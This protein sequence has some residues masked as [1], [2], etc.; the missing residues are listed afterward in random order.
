MIRKFIILFP[1]LVTSVSALVI[2]HDTPTLDYENYGAQAQFNASLNI[3][4]DGDAEFGALAGSTAID[5][6]WGIHARHTLRSVS[7]WLDDGNVARIRG[8]R[9][10]GVSFQG[11][12]SVVVNQ[13]IHYDDDFSRF[14]N[15]IDI[16]LVQSKAPHSG[17]RIAPIYGGWDEVGRVGSAASA[18]NNRNNGNGVSA[19]QEAQD[20]SNSNRWYE[21]RWGGKN[22]INVL[23]GSSFQGSPA[24]AILNLDFDH[25]ADTS[26]SRW[27]GNTAI[28]LEYGS[29]NGD[30]GSPLYLEKDG[31][32]GQVAGVV[33]GGS[34][35]VY[36]SS[37]VY[38]R[39]RAYKNWITDTV[40]E[41]PDNRTLA[42]DSISDQLVNLGES[43]N[44]VASASG[45][46]LPPQSV[47]YSLVN[48]PVGASIDPVTG[49]F[50]WTPEAF[51]AG[52][53]QS[54]T[55]QAKEDG[56][57]ANAVTS[58]FAVTING[59]EVTDFWS[60]SGAN[61]LGR[62]SREVTHTA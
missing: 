21:V 31:V 42:L 25:P 2:R 56:V 9:G 50:S 53:T 13:V 47:T 29:M 17:L 12:G 45:S 15:A 41:N 40:L 46:E 36:G 33:S 58:D 18:A 38:V 26:K 34:G 54:I 20:T 51:V 22:E 3:H 1:V 30:S 43:V 8:T 60:W 10:K 11:L 28:D 37:I 32:V 5:S 52:T 24:N 49:A 57:V 23:S 35:N 59:S 55:V 27:G 7:D 6:R 4:Q 61:Q 14:T 44:L 16:A 48:S 39:T 19:K 62:S